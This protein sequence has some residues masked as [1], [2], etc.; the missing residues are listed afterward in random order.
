MSALVLMDIYMLCR[1][2]VGASS[3]S[4][5][6]LSGLSVQAAGLHVKWPVSY[7]VNNFEFRIISSIFYLSLGIHQAFLQV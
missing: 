3:G 1:L 2:T 5:I 7:C 6:F 4:K